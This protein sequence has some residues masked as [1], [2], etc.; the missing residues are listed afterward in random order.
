MTN[1]LFDEIDE[2]LGVGRNFGIVGIQGEDQWE[3]L[4]ECEE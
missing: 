4:T 2:S 1:E 3:E